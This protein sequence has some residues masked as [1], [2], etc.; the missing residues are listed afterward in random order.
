MTSR[1]WRVRV[2]VL[3]T[4]LLFCRPAS[5]QT[6]DPSFEADIKTLME[7]TGAAALGTQMAS[8]A[9]RQVFD[10]MRRSQPNV[11][12]RAIEVAREVLDAEFAK[13]FSAPDGVTPKMVAIYAQH[14][15]QDDV[16]SL[17]A[18]YRSDLGRK[19][20]SEMPALTREGAAA[21]EMWMRANIGRISA[22]LQERLKA[23]GLIK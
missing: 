3:A 17:I 22:T 7:L 14:F 6:I 20:V 15:T 16:R 19:V 21:G 18:F 5:G 8:L 12:E 4:A 23:E 2:I 10:A 9:S 13:A 1:R 11:S